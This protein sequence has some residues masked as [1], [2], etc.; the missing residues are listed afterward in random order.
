MI[1]ALEDVEAAARAIAGSVIETPTVRSPRLSD[2][3]GADIRLKLENLHYT[4]SFKERGALN[5]LLG[6]D[7]AERSAGVIAMSAGNHAQAVAHHA[8]GL[9]IAATI[10]MPKNTPF[11]KVSNTEALGATVILEGNDLAASAAFAAREA[12]SRGLVVVHPYEDPRVIAGQGTV[13]LEMLRAAPDLE[14]LVVPVGGGGLIAGCIVAARGINPDI[15]IVGVQ[16]GRC[17]AMLAAIRGT[18]PDIRT[19][20][21]AEGIAV[22]QPGRIT[23]D[24]VSASGT[25]IVLVE[26]GGI[27]SAIVLLAEAEK[28]VVEGAGAAAL[29]AVL[30]E[31]DRFAGRR[32]GVVVSGGNID[33]RLLAG[34]L[35]RG[36]VRV[37]RLVRLR[38]E[39]DDLPGNLARLTRAVGGLGGDIVDVA[40]QRWFYDVPARKTLA[41]L[42]VEVR[43]PGE[44][45]KLF[46]GLVEEGYSVTR[47]GSTSET[48]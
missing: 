5:Y 23:R 37:G 8:R 36:L 45:D 48:R 13:A 27:E 31:R 12:E 4:A 32:V 18:D 46:D 17:P 11:Q 3:L 43:S 35:M 33:P 29:A 26:E 20:T 24:I 30:A 25:D 41:D 10:V 38:V 42:L 44:A 9:G 19:D 39:I 2:M 40:H 22:K 7:A 16:A 15:E 6:L 21:L 14:T 34:V 1:V 47:L 28:L